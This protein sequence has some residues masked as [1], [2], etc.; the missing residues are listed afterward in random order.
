MSSEDRS[1]EN[2]NPSGLKSKFGGYKIRFLPEEFNPKREVVDVR[3]TTM[4]GDEFS[5]NFVP[6]TY[7]GYLFDKNKRTGE[8]AS[9]SYFCMPG[10]VV[11]EK[12]DKSTIRKTVDDLILN[13]EIEEYFRKL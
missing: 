2:R 9:G 12:V 7:L 11:V 1:K 5:A 6:H 8:C 10:M 4:G 3:L 13:L